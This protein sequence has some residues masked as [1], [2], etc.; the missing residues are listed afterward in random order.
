MPLVVVVGDG[1]GGGGVACECE[2]EPPCG[3]DVEEPPQRLC[4]DTVCA[5]TT[6]ATRMIARRRAIPSL[7]TRRAT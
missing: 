1:G 5:I 3:I 7:Y 2:R 4:A 6:A